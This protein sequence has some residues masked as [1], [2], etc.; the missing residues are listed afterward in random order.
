MSHGPQKQRPQRRRVRSSDGESPNAQDTDMYYHVKIDHKSP[1]DRG[2][3]GE[4]LSWEALETRVVA[5]YRRGVPITLGGRTIQSSYIDTVKI[6]RTSARVDRLDENKPFWLETD[7][8]WQA[9][10]EDVTDLIITAP[11]GWDLEEQTLDSVKSRQ[12][13]NTREVFVVH[14]RNE[15]ARKALFGFLRAIGLVPLEWAMAVQATGK[16]SPYISEILDVAFDRAQAIVVLLTPDDEARLKEPHQVD[17]DPPHDTEL[18]GQARPNVLF[19]AGI[20]MARNQDRTILV[21]LGVLRP[22]SDI[23]GRHVIRLDNSSQRRHDLAQRLE[24]AGC[25]VNLTGRDWHSEGDFEETVAQSVQS[26]TVPMGPTQGRLPKEARALLVEAANDGRALITRVGTMGGLRIA[27]RRKEFCESGDPRSEVAWTGALNALVN[28][29]LV[30]DR[31]G[32]GTV[33]AVTDKGF[34]YADSLDND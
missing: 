22:F 23:A 3:H 17:D 9:A 34:K 32:K 25:P 6:A 24:A 15:E 16:G 8:T 33:F 4:N 30:E 5:P 26:A 13:A 19:E 31:I 2:I 10:E 28:E 18:T 1:N 20:A 7:H 12:A 29:G 14:G 11:P 27:T 21:E